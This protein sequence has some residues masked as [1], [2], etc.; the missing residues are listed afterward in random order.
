DFQ[1]ILPTC[2]KSECPAIPKTNVENIIG[3][4]IVFTS[5]INPLLKGCSATATFGKSTPTNTPK[6][7]LV[8]IHVV[9]FFLRNA[10]TINVKATTHLTL[11]ITSGANATLVDSLIKVRLIAIVIISSDTKTV[12]ELNIKFFFKSIQ[13]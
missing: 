13:K 10:F 3:A 4:T 5:L 6:I 2:F 11:I 8:I 9:R 1:A 7:I 12:L